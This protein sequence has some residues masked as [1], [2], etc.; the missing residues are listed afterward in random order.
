MRVT[1]VYGHKY[2]VT[3]PDVVCIDLEHDALCNLT[4]FMQKL[5]DSGK[6][7]LGYEVRLSLQEEVYAE[8]VVVIAEV[9]YKSVDG[10]GSSVFEVLQGS[11]LVKASEEA[12]AENVNA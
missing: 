9:R 7:D 12:K 8:G 4:E 11:D 6:V 5:Y 2:L 1:P 3:K 10:F